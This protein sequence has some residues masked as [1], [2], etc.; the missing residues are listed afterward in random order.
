M[1]FT[2]L[3]SSKKCYWMEEQTKLNETTNLTFAE[4]R[5]DM[6]LQWFAYQAIAYLDDILVI[7]EEK[8]D[9]ETADSLISFRW[10][11]E[12]K[13]VSIFLRDSA[14][15]L[16]KLEHLIE[17][18]RR[19]ESEMIDFRQKLKGTLLEATESL[20]ELYM[21]CI[22]NSLLI[23]KK[24]IHQT[25]PSK[26]ILSQILELQDQIKTILR[27]QH[28]MDSLQ[29]TFEDYRLS[30]IDYIE[31]RENSMH[32]Y[33]DEIE[34]IHNTIKNQ[35]DKLNKDQITKLYKYID[36]RLSELEKQ[37]EYSPYQFIVLEDTDK[38]KVPVK[39]EDSKL[40]FKSIDILSEIN[41]WTS[42]NLT[43][44]LKNLDNKL[45]IFKEK[46]KSSLLQLS[47]RLKARIEVNSEEP[48]DKSDLI[49]YTSR[50]KKE[51][52][53]A[54]KGE[55]L[56]EFIKIKDNLNAH[57]VPSQVFNDKYNFLPF[58]SMN[59]LAGFA[60]NTDLERR[61]SPTRI[62]AAFKNRI[63]KIFSRYS[64]EEHITAAGYVKNILSFDPELESN[65][66]FLKS[67][68]LGS[69]FSVNR[70]D[71]LIK[72]DKHFKLWQEGFGG[73]LLLHGGHLSGKSTIIEM[74][75]IN[76][77]DFESH[78][79]IPGQR[80]DV[81]GHKLIIK[82]DLMESLHFIAK[83]SRNSKCIVTIDDLHQYST[84][85]EKTFSLFLELSE[86]ITK[87]SRHI[88]FVVSM[89][90]YL[91]NRLSHYFDLKRI[92]SESIDTDFSSLVDIEQA[93]LTRAHAVVNNED[94]MMGNEAIS[95]LARK[96]TKKSNGN[97]G[98][99]MQLWC[100]YNSGN[101]RDDL[102][103]GHFK[104]LIKKH[105]TLI[106]TFIIHGAI[107]EPELRNL[108][109]DI[110]SRGIKL[111]IDGLIQQMILVRMAEGKVDLNP[112]LK[113]FIEPLV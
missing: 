111:N 6:S 77:I 29:K 28:K 112:Y 27:C 75:P 60:E 39:T 71:I 84:N 44:P 49:A 61:Y 72:I 4:L 83:H 25:N 85:P 10:T 56:D 107:Y 79:I 30:Y 105:D 52:E 38:L 97:I 55:S 47:N 91:K 5:E 108:Y 99:A 1:G 33:H 20:D 7:L 74:I 94:M 68:F 59:Q 80:I 103:A 12:A 34:N 13:D 89:H 41:G 64:A 57:I 81:N 16:F 106:K 2:I 58:S 88:Y 42:F 98:K 65:N 67:G 104:N 102:D 95:S 92:F 82:N 14:L 37:K 87:N 36:L 50:L 113:V 78:H 23:N 35:E 100:M 17:D 110:N 86:F 46:V 63:D 109:N 18:G 93:V 43:T 40:V 90:K 45:H 24:W 51:Y 73:G 26:I 66:L 9:D 32:H 62:R 70:D 101:Y 19:S 15:N 54:I 8:L 76:Y 48:V 69:S 22:S 21:K 11:F 53:I 96:V 3:E 31:E